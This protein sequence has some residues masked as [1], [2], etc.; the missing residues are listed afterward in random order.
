MIVKKQRK[1]EKKAKMIKQS[2]LMQTLFLDME[3]RD[4][5]FV[6]AAVS[7]LTEHFVLH[8]PRDNC[9]SSKVPLKN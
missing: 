8:V 9:M 4:P 1:N 2:K 6:L 7:I 3:Y 5:L